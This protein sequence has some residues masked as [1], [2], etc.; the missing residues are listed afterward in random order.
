M[1]TWI[2]AAARAMVVLAACTVPLATSWAPASSAGSASPSHRPAIYHRPIIAIGANQSSNWSGYNQG[3]L[4]QNQ[5][6]FN[7]VSGTWHVPTATPHKQ[8]E[9]EYSSSWVGIGGGCVDKD[10]QITDGTLIQAGTEQD[11]GTDGSAAYSAWWEIIPEPATTITSLTI[12][13]GDTMF[14][15]ITENPAGS[16]MWDIVV[17]DVTTGKQ[18]TTSTPYPSSY[19]TVEWIEETPVVVDDQGNVTVGPLP[20]LST[21]KFAKARD[22]GKAAKLVASEAIQLVD[23]NTSEV[24]ATPSD[25]NRKGTKFHVCT[26]A[27]TCTL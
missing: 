6:Q 21:V 14:V 25:P 15:S 17:K 20:S 10:C 5:K 13:A 4:E 27:T 9:A 1:R 16:E 7:S 2:G 12:H 26:Y 3:Y 19:A 18:F 11:V 8:G 24:L 23:P 22:D